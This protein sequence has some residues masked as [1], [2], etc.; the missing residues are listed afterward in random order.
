M[1]NLREAESVSVTV[2]VDNY[3]DLFLLESRGVMR[4]PP[5]RAA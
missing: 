4:R 2:L 3:T 1:M 5:C